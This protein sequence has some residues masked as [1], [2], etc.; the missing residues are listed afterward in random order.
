VT[1]QIM[2]GRR[3]AKALKHEVAEEVSRLRGHRCRLATVMVGQD[4]SAGAYERRL[5]RV[6]DELGVGYQ[7]HTLPASSAVEDVL[8]VIGGLNADPRVSGILV[9]RPLPAQVDEALVFTALSPH[10]DIEAVHP[11]NAGLLALG[12]PRFMPSTPA[13]VF[14][15]LDSWLDEVGESRPEFYHR[16]TIV[17]VGRSNNVGKPAALLGYA[18]QAVTVSCDEWV[19]RTGRLAEVTSGADVLIVAAGVAGLIGA[20]HVS[21]EM[22]VLDVG[23]NPVTDPV[24]GAVHL[25][26]DVDFAAVAP[27]VR[28]ISP[29]PG[30]VGPVTDVWLMRNTAAAARLIMAAGS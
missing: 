18:R 21:P 3:V 7:G 12:T 9:L 19:S 1:A 14:Y 20:E 16:S 23:I 13:S 26:G 17:V 10:K 30:G 11:V 22:V 5:V 15:L 8:A 2:D 24:E 27:V 4:Y 28:A 29:V 25:V 6:A